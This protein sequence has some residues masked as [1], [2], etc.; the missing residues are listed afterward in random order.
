MDICRQSTADNF[1]KVDFALASCKYNTKV[2]VNI[3]QSWE[4]AM[5]SRK[6][7]I[8]MRY[9]YKHPRPA[10][11]VDCVVFGL[12]SKEV[13]KVLLIRRD[14]NP[15]KDQWALP[16]GFVNPEIDQS[17][18]KAA[19][20]ELSEET[21]VQDIYLEQLCT[22]GDSVRDPREWIASVAYYALVNLS[23]HEIHADTDA[24]DA[25]WFSI[26]MLPEPLA[27][28]HK[29]ILDIAISRLRGKIRYTPIGFEL[30]PQKFT[31]AQLQKLYE[32]VLG[33]KLD[34]RNF[35]REFQST[36]LL[37]DLN[38]FQQAV[39]HRPAKLYQFNKEKYEN[40]CR[41]GGFNFTIKLAG[42][43]SKNVL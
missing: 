2:S 21:G 27:F 29:V 42:T 22:F 36:D 39:S 28:D 14:K 25:S 7:M 23:E 26:S 41:N 35:L 15:F 3:T 5:T 43:L 20:R 4:Y 40:L 9:Q 18:E 17:L 6:E 37:I 10:L 1:R 12:D 32:I 16:G 8:D 31:L 11:S 34:K 24:N 38:E 19:R 13:L 33:E 30:L